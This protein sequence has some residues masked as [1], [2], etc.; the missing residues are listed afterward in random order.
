M[1]D[2][3]LITIEFLSGWNL[4]ACNLPEEQLKNILYSI[5]AGKEFDCNFNGAWRV[6]RNTL[7]GPPINNSPSRGLFSHTT[8]AALVAERN[9]EIPNTSKFGISWIVLDPA[10]GNTA[11][12]LEKRYPGVREDF[13]KELNVELPETVVEN[14]K[15]YYPVGYSSSNL[16]RS[17]LL[18]GLIAFMLRMYGINATFHM[19]EETV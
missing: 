8:A 9:N 7:Y 6:T 2:S 19:I 18:G 11:K 14:N 4:S 5:L 15:L 10:D 1:N 12:W 13:K 17:I 16:L 3:Y